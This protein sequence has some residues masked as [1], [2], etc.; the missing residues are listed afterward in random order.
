[1]RPPAGAGLCWEGGGVRGRRAGGPP[2]PASAW[3]L[4]TRPVRLF[5]VSV[6]VTL[7]IPP[8]EG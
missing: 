8:R 7:E 3:V 1:M 2:L 5:A 4:G 6:L